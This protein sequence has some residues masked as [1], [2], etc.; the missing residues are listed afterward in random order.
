MHYMAPLAMHYM[1]MRY[2]A[3]HDMAL[4]DDALHCNV[5]HCRMQNWS[6]QSLHVTHGVLG[7][8]ALAGEVARTVAAVTHLMHYIDART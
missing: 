7:V 8:G 1:A 4:H 2:M 6:V 5:H 3:M